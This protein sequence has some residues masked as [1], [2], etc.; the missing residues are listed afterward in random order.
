[1]P[2]LRRIFEQQCK[3]TLTFEKIIEDLR[4]EK[5]DVMI[6]ETFDYCGIGEQL[7]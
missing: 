7:S 2:L 5:Y 6:V 3:Y 4:R 1:M